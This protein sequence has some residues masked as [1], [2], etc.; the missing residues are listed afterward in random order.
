MI[1]TAIIEDNLEVRQ[2]LLSMLGSDENICCTASFENA[3]E[4]LIC[5]KNQDCDVAL[6]DIH[7]PGKSGIEL[8]SELKKI[9]PG[10]Q[11][12]V[13]TVFEDT[14]N[15]FNALKAGATGYILK[16]TSPAKILDSITEVHQGG[17]PMSSQIARKVICTFFPASGEPNKEQDSLSKREQE[18]L[19]L[20]S[21]GYRYK[22]IG[23]KLFISTETVRTHIRNIY[24]KL[25]VDSGIEA[26]N[27]VYG[28]NTKRRD[29]MPPSES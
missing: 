25:Q 19:L 17:S 22:E 15:I 16:G 7:L 9:K 3:E 13:L 12:I 14:D 28:I 8:I 2:A 18:I 1:K 20:L 5:L 21:K 23:E 29:V 26:I 4:A 27:K 24:H 10:I 6:V 11:C